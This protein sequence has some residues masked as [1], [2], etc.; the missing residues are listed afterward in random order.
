VGIT[1]A[2]M[3]PLLS[4]RP[5]LVL[6][7]VAAIIGTATVGIAGAA[8]TGLISACVNRAGQLRIITP[9]T[10]TSRDDRDDER[11][12]GACSRNETLLTWSQAGPQGPAGPTGATGPAG[13]TGATGA[14][15]ASGAPAVSI[16][17]GG[18]PGNV[19][20]GTTWYVALYA[21]RFSNTE[22]V[23]AQAVPVAGTMHRLFADAEVDPGCFHP[24]GVNCAAQYWSLTVM[25]NGSPTALVCQITGSSFLNG[26]PRA[27]CFDTVDTVHFAAGDLVT[28]R[29]EGSLFGPAPSPIHWTAA[30][31][32]D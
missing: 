11:P 10:S 17:G 32:T 6:A 15:G 9:G 27:P 7:L 29:V 5:G 18:T 1:P 31:T 16:L 8:G 14:T 22:S 13:A 4:G 25:K 21:P 20:S 2:F 30:F 24:G 19:T 23:V 12:N 28:I 3:R 26:T